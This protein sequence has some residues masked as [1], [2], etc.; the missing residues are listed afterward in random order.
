MVTA[1]FSSLFAAIDSCKQSM[2]EIR[3][4]STCNVKQ[5]TAAILVPYQGNKAPTVNIGNTRYGIFVGT[6]QN[7]SHNCREKGRFYCTADRLNPDRPTGNIYSEIRRLQCVMKECG[8]VQ[9]GKEVLELIENP[10]GGILLSSEVPCPRCVDWFIKHPFVKYLF[11]EKMNENS[12]SESSFKATSAYELSDLNVLAGVESFWLR[13]GENNL[14]VIPGKV[15]QLP[16]W[17]GKYAN[18]PVFPENG[19]NTE[20]E[21][22]KTLRVLCTMLIDASARNIIQMI[23]PEPPVD[24]PV[25]WRCE[26]CTTSG[27]L[28][29]SSWTPSKF[30]HGLLE[31]AHTTVSPNCEN[32]HFITRFPKGAPGL[33]FDGIG[34]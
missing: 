21:I 3:D 20:L 29:Y 30:I 33:R 26:S 7:T 28:E 24:L 10:S 23:Y 27:E 11:F 2:E 18:R 34:A 22:E 8:E 6:N 12:V 25:H 17:T 4:Q 32:T 15:F 19:P 14:E 5:V 9:A 13:Q 16:G 31:E 1:L